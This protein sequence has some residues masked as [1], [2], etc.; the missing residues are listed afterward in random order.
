MRANDELKNS[1]TSLTSGTFPEPWAV[2]A[3]QPLPPRHRVVQSGVPVCGR[4]RSA[5]QFRLGAVTRAFPAGSP[6]RFFQE[7]LSQNSS[8]WLPLDNVQRRYRCPRR[9]AGSQLPI[10]WTPNL[11]PSSNRCNDSPGTGEEQFSSCRIPSDYARLRILVEW[12]ALPLS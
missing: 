12:P 1:H 8:L 10:I 6:G 7:G 4:G 5:G 2:I 3:G 11:P 9:N